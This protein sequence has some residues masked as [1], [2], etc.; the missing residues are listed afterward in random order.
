MIVVE[1]SPIEARAHELAKGLEDF[2]IES[3]FQLDAHVQSGLDWAEAL[4]RIAPLVEAARSARRKIA[5]ATRYEIR[6]VDAS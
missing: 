2:Q 1:L 6:V 3:A 5:E 4:E